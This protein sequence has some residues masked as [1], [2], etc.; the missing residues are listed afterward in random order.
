MQLH[1]AEA[2]NL[3]KNNKN[4]KKAHNFCILL[5][6]KS[7]KIRKKYLPLRRL[8]ILRILIIFRV[9]H[10]NS[11]CFLST[12][13]WHSSGRVKKGICI[14]V[15][16]GNFSFTFLSTRSSTYEGQRS[17]NFQTTN[18]GLCNAGPRSGPCNQSYC[19]AKVWGWLGKESPS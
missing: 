14:L 8:G 4:D 7:F 5:S 13:S 11:G 9:W 16:R 18:R 1:V 6:E 19:K 15:A 12:G 10:E 2:K 17:I 3:P